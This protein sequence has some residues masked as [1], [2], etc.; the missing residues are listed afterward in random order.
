MG[1]FSSSV[2]RKAPVADSCA[3][4]RGKSRRG[5][6]LSTALALMLEDASATRGHVWSAAGIERPFETNPPLHP[7]RPPNP[8]LHSPFSLAPLGAGGRFRSQCKYIFS[9][10]KTHF[11]TTVKR[12]GRVLWRGEG[13]ERRERGRER[14]GVKF[15]PSSSPLFST[16]SRLHSTSGTV[17][18]L[19]C[20]FRQEG[21]G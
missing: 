6:N 3:G 15:F 12:G 14:V 21:K 17:Y 16:L 20:W 18:H 11:P 10:S 7:A 8:H 2:E 4:D 19:A 13:N 5:S 1:R 9:L